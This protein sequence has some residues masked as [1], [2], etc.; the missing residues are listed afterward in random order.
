MSSVK[1]PPLPSG[2]IIGKRPSL[3]CIGWK[4]TQKICDEFENKQDA[5]YAN[6]LKSF[7]EQ[8]KAWKN[9]N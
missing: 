4:K 1:K 6:S 2:S 7:K 3:Y 5:E 9:S 8:L